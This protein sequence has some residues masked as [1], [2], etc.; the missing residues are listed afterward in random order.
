MFAFGYDDLPGL[1]DPRALSKAADAAPGALP[2]FGAGGP[3]EKYISEPTRKSTASRS[4][5]LAGRLRYSM[6][7]EDPNSTGGAL[8]PSAQ[9]A[10]RGS[11]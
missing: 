2:S 1:P 6:N 3:M 4:A 11:K 5:F 8:S 10:A 9:A 7:V